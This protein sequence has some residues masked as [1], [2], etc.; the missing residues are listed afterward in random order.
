MVLSVLFKES[1]E[2]RS[3]I[4]HNA[5]TLQNA[6]MHAGTTSDT[7]LR[8][9]LEWLALASNWSKFSA[10]AGLG[11][12]HKGHFVEGMNILGPYLPQPGVESGIPGAVY[13]E[14]GALYA[15][16][17]INA[18]CGSGRQVEGYLRDALKATQNE[19]VQHGAALGLGV[20]GMGGKSLEAYE[21]LKQTLFH[22]SA[23][24]GEAAG[25]AMGLVMLGT[26]DANCADEMLTY[27]R[28]TQ[29]EKIIRGLAIGLAFIYY[30]RQ[31]QA[32][33][34]ANELINEKVCGCSTSHLVRRLISGCSRTPFSGTVVSTPSPLPTP[35]RRTTPPS[36]NCSTSPSPIPRTT[37]AEL[38]SQ[39]WRSFSSRT[40]RKYRAS[41]SC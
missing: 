29:H 34:I 21:D 27:A 32:D 40:P 35:A 7:F 8:E 10:T 9:N 15:L 37:C 33:T 11:V 17:L 20:A 26:G 38:Q 39:R 4:Y 23:V 19:V 18:G 5:L 16:G 14:G 1:L 13:S 30:G 41:S 31:E 6:F 25:Y 22:D 2:G 36:A 12:I 3:S 28:E 24:S